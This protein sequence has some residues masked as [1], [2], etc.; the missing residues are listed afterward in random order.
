MMVRFSDII[1]IKD[2]KEPMSEST[3]KKT[4][5]DKLRLRDSQILRAKGEMGVVDPSTIEDGR[6]EII[7]YFEKF[8]ESAKNIRDRVKNDQGISPSP[9]LAD[10]HYIINN[11]LIDLLYEYAISSPEH[12]DVMLVHTVNVTFTSLKVGK[13][14]DYD[15]EMLL[16]LGL[17]AFLEN[18]GMYKITDSIIKKKGRLE[19]GEKSI[20]EE[21]P[22]ISYEILGQM[23]KRYKWLSEVA[24][25]A[26]E[27]ADGSGYPN[28]LKGE[29]IT[30]LALI[31][32][33]IDTYA[34]M[35]K[36]RI[37]RDK[38]EP[39]DAV[40]YIIK[41]KKDLFPSRILK[42]FL[43]QISLFPV[44]T[45]VR[46]NNKSIGQVLSTDQKQ[47]LRP[48]IQLLYDGLGNRM[49]KQEVVRLS[50]NPLLYIID[51]IH[52]EDLP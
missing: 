2:I 26:H 27:R 14:M 35:I 7:T 6:L 10:L 36:N 34:S 3:E 20:L 11:N 44:E 28:G 46:L 31:I 37:Y 52:E 39:T 43:N 4:L 49:E 47:P 48:T 40:K 41:D 16:K 13:G 21:H 19:E 38:L 24:L 45:Y 5:V 18:V 42:V 23:G 8:I 32:G 51:S 25:Q 22:K 33:L 29:E 50:E 30:E 12:D 15:T 1:K 9:I 17:A